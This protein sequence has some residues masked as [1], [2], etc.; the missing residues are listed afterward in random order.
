MVADANIISLPCM[1]LNTHLISIVICES[2]IYRITATSLIFMNG[3]E[4]IDE[5]RSVEDKISHH[6]GASELS[7]VKL[8]FIYYNRCRES[9]FISKYQEWY[10]RNSI[11]PCLESK[12]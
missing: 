11:S 10:M 12:R 9:S 3:V 5:Q 4:I 1:L 6:V 7:D 2:Y 8:I